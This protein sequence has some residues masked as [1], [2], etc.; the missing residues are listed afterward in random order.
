M[1]PGPGCYGYSIDSASAMALYFTIVM[2]IL[3]LASWNFDDQADKELLG[4]DFEV[5]KYLILGQTMLCVFGTVMFFKQYTSA[6]MILL[7]FWV[8]GAIVVSLFLD[9]MCTIT[10]TL[11]LTLEKGLDRFW[12]LRDPVATTAPNTLHF[13][14]IALLFFYFVFKL[15]V[16]II[17]FSFGGTFTK[18]AWDDVHLVNDI[19]RNASCERTDPP[20]PPPQYDQCVMES[21]KPPPYSSSMENFKY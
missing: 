8:F 18:S 1:Q 17:V 5:K 7:K 20:T 2:N 10:T 12:K 9:L 14:V 11:H 15:H 13:F 3:M 16:A 21:E 6:V 19:E 4:E